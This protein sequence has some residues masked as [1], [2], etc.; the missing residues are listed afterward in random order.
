MSDSLLEQRYVDTVFV[1]NMMSLL[2]Y[3]YLLPGKIPC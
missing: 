2:I 1:N 3:T